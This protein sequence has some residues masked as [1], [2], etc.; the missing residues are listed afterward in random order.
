MRHPS[1]AGLVVSLTLAGPSVL[2]AQP[3]TRAETAVPAPAPAPAAK[4]RFTLFNPT[5]W[6][7]AR[8]LSTD[9]PDMTES[10]YT[11]PAGRV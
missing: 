10:P 7:Q 1:L 2:A 9:R 4:P 6:A 8:E 5:P 3:G 11:V